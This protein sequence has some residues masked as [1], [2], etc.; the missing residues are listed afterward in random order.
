MKL[1]NLA[2]R[3]NTELINLYGRDEIDAIFLIVIESVLGYRRSDYLL[4]RDEDLTHAQVIELNNTL[5]Q[6][7]AGKPVQYILGETIFYGL[8]FKV[9]PSVLIPRPE[10]EELVDWVITSMNEI[11]RSEGLGKPLNIID[12]GT[13]SGCIAISLKKNLPETNVYG[14]DIA[15]DSL[16]IAEQNALMNEVSVNFIHADILNDSF[17][18]AH[19]QF[20]III[21]NPPYITQHEKE[22]MHENVLNNEPHRA[23]FVSNEKPLIFYE[24]IADF[25]KENLDKDGLLFLEINEYYSK[26]TMDLL[27]DKGFKSIEL[28]KDMQ[29]KNRMVRAQL[30]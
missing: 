19:L 18:I 15:S 2:Q 6:L 30:E 22:A 7:K 13:G 14:L 8:P 17:S 25:A 27:S 3:F 20:S 10:T 21:S 16:E 4:K 1:R 11:P 28:R 12:I 29:G 23:L 26:E 5:G 24:A 9:N